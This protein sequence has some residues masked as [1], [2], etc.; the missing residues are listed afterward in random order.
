L[1]VLERR[2][3]RDIRNLIKVEERQKRKVQSCIREGDFE[4]AKQIARD[5]VFTKKS[6]EKYVLIRSQVS[7]TK[8]SLRTQYVYSSIQESMQ[9]ITKMYRDANQYMNTEQLY[10]TIA[11]FEQE[12]EKHSIFF[13][14]FDEALETID[15]DEDDEKVDNV[16]DEII[17][18]ETIKMLQQLKMPPEHLSE[19][20]REQNRKEKLQF[21]Q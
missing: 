12:K 17:N 20:G 18:S 1:G 8:T 19:F 4:N 3:D 16:L 21:E 7:E 13:E 11:V 5:A 15:N 10:Q 14:L 2:I 9:S 6:I